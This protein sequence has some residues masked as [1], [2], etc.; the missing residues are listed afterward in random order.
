M[1]REQFLEV[2]EK[3]KSKN[4]NSDYYIDL[5]FC[6]YRIG[7]IYAYGNIDDIEVEERFGHVLVYTNDIGV[8]VDRAE[9]LSI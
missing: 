2:L 5:W 1:N 8:F 6:G 4:G 9:V 7:S 3:L